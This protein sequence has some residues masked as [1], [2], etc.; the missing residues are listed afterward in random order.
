MPG[1]KT[2]DLRVEKPRSGY[3]RKQGR[4]V[5]YYV[6]TAYHDKAPGYV[7][8]MARSLLVGRLDASG[9][10]EPNASYFA[11]FGASE[12]DCRRVSLLASVD[13][14]R[15]V[16]T[17]YSVG[18]DLFVDAAVRGL[19]IEAPLVSALGARLA[20]TAL[21]IARF[22]CLCGGAVYMADAQLPKHPS[23]RFDSRSASAA[24]A[25]LESVD[26]M[27][28][29]R[30][31]AR[32]AAEIGGA[33]GEDVVAYDVTSI[34]RRGSLDPRSEAGYNRDHDPY[35]QI[36]V[37]M[38]TSVTSR[39]PLMPVLH[40]GSALDQE[41]LEAAANLARKAGIARFD[42]VCDGAF[43]RPEQVAALTR[44]GVG[45]IVGMPASRD[46]AKALIDANR[47]AATS[48]SAATE[49]RSTY[50][51][52]VPHASY[53]VSGTACV[54]YN[55]QT[56]DLENESCRQALLRLEAE[57]SG[58]R[59]RKYSTAVKDG[60]YT[61][62]F[63]IAPHDG[64]AGYDW[65]RSAEKIEEATRRNGFAVIFSSREGDEASRIVFSYREKDA[66]EKV[67][68]EWKNPLESA[69]LHTHGRETTEGKAFVLFLSAV[70]NAYVRRRTGEL[71]RRRG[72]SLAEVYQYLNLIEAVRVKGV[73]VPA[74]AVT[75]T[76]R[77][78]LGTM[79]LTEAD[80]Y[81]KAG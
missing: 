80:L 30:A 56:A 74:S 49:Y 34:T 2:S 68:Y 21:S 48:M 31:W 43:F 14:S 62:L 38:F 10:L 41:G 5:Y 13:L 23:W 53:G 44:M 3:A 52:A 66:D 24:F 73:P 61:S 58:R 1:F 7:P 28:F 8:G 17:V 22:F 59:R 25:E 18:F 77:E 16:S 36:N 4:Q 71:M 50:A 9:F 42:V 35:P 40:A 70:I 11:F 6:Y 33:G 65:A 39:L 76:H 27:P 78:I 19:G 45:F 69:R 67:F 12:S 81:P 46:E 72:Y 60:R 15:D 79:G 29:Y 37:G 51:V 20:R 54:V 26:K 64:D 47:D 32:R 63:D 55:A 57:L 75:K